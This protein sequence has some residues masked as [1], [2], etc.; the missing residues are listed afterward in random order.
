MPNYHSD[1]ARRARRATTLKLRREGKT[2]RQICD[3]LGVGMSIARSDYV[4]ALGDEQN[5]H[6]CCELSVRAN[7]VLWRYMQCDRTSGLER[8]DPSNVAM[9]SRQALLDQDACGI[10]TIREIEKWLSQHGQPTLRP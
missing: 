1:D 2:F 5:P 8:M 3:A 7:N 6:P 10:K 9:L 4:I